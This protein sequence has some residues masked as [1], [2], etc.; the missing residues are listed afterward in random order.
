[1]MDFYQAQQIQLID[2]TPRKRHIELISVR[3][4]STKRKGSIKNGSHRKIFE[5]LY[6]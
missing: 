2:I 1:M 5:R 6:I 4:K 3:R